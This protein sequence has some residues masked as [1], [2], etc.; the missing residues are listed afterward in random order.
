MLLNNQVVP[1]KEQFVTFMKTYPKDE[2]V[3]MINLLKFKEK[4]GK[5]EESGR[6]AYKRYGKNVQRLLDKVGGKV[7][8]AGEVNMTVIGDPTD[9][10]D[11]VA[12]V[13]YPSAQKFV[14]MSTS[15]EYQPIGVDR[16]ISL[17]YGGLLASST[18]SLG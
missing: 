12:I 3:V 4:S 14:E 13:E 10:P 9:H 11:M 6:E 2:P 17:T 8:W 15:A 16:E 5:G 1:T 7:L 18:S